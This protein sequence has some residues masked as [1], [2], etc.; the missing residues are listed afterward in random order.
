[1]RALNMAL[2]VFEANDPSIHYV[3]KY[4]IKC[5]VEDAQ[6]AEAEKQCLHALKTLET[7]EFRLHH[8]H[9]SMVLEQHTILF[10]RWA[11]LRGSSKYAE[12]EVACQEMMRMQKEMRIMG[13]ADQRIKTVSSGVMLFQC[14]TSLMR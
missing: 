4:A 8:D 12:A 9:K 6:Y 7:E 2:I 11:A 5:L 3:R 14:T 10:N 13:L 1:M